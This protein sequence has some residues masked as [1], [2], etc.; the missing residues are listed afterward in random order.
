M[1]ASTL[2]RGPAIAPLLNGRLTQLGECLP[3]KQKVAGSSPAV[4]TK[5]GLLVKW[6]HT[7]LSRWSQGIDTPTDRKENYYELE[8]E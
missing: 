4:T 2:Q 1:P 5:I 3:Y 7:T 8:E 6:N